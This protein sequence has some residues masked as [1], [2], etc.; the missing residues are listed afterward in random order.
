VGLTFDGQVEFVSVAVP[1]AWR[2]RL[3]ATNA[4]LG[5]GTAY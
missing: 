4:I 3:T 2:V 5:I 1:A